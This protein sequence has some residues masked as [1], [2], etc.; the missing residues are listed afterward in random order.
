MTS[1]TDPTSAR[2]LQHLP[3]EYD[4][5]TPIE[6]CIELLARLEV[7]AT[8]VGGKLLVSMDDTYALFGSLGVLE[9]RLALIE[10]IERI[11]R[12]EAWLQDTANG[13]LKFELLDPEED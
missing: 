10:I 2:P 9:R 8:G 5:M 13:V 7:T 3:S 6:R 4:A 12:K 1:K 11:S